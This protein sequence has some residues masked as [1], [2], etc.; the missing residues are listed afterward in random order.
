M[1]LS[2]L[3]PSRRR[4][5][6]KFMHLKAVMS[7]GWSSTLPFNLAPLRQQ[8]KVLLLPSSLPCLPGRPECKFD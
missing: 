8:Q 6:G 7:N 1:H 5:G 3:I 2:L 4:T